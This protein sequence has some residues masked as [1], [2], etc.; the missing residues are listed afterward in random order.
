MRRELRG[1][2]RFC[3]LELRFDLKKVAVKWD[4]MLYSMT[5][6]CYSGQIIRLKWRLSPT[7]EA[8]LSKSIQVWVQIPETPQLRFATVRG[9]GRG[10]LVQVTDQSSTARLDE[11]S[12][13]MLA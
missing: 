3:S 13:D 10:A 11:V 9:I 12:L 5:T 4:R 1:F 6:I 8:V 2:A 7:A